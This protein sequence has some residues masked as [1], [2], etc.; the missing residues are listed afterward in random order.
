MFRFLYVGVKRG[1]YK[2][3]KERG[4]EIIFLGFGE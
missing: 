4:K 2:G 3:E 1:F